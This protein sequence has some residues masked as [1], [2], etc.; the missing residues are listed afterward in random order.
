[1]AMHHISGI[2][3]LAEGVL[4]PE[5]S[6]LILLHDIGYRYCLLVYK[7]GILLII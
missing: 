4:T 1:M 2:K 6:V 7:P 3:A 5:V